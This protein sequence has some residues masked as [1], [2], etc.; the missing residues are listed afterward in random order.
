[1]GD[2]EPDRFLKWDEAA[3]TPLDDIMRAFEALKNAPMRPQGSAADVLNAIAEMVR[4]GQDSGTG[5]VVFEMDGRPFAV[6][7]SSVVRACMA[8][9]RAFG[10]EGTSTEMRIVVGEPVGDRKM[11]NLFEPTN[12]RIQQT[13][14]VE[15]PAVRA[16][17][18][19]GPRA[20]R[21][22]GGRWRR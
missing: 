15:D 18:T 12:A 14:T 21:P 4:S 17:D 11:L 20:P 13:F 9:M 5:T 3:S 22:F 6:L 2:A 1:M 7:P 16:P 19:R 8:E 10:G